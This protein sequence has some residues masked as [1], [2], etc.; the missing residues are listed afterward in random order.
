MHIC[1]L[2]ARS[3]VGLISF[4]FENDKLELI[5]IR[6]TDDSPHGILPNFSDDSSQIG[7]NLPHFKIII[8]I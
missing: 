3:P 2:N 4:M 5:I 7:D 6:P 8:Y 1:F